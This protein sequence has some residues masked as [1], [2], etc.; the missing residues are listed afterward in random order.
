VLLFASLFALLMASMSD[1]SASFRI[2]KV[3]LKRPALSVLGKWTI[4]FETRLIASRSEIDN[5][6]TTSSSHSNT[7][8]VFR[9]E[10]LMSA[11][12][13]LLNRHFSQNP[14]CRSERVIACHPPQLARLIVPG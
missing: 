10:H 3:A 12:Q 13:L 11:G 7:R 8:K 1:L 6:V 4:A 2:A 5:G 14:L 9:A